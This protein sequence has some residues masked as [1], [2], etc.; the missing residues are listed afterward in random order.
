MGNSDSDTVE[1][2]KQIKQ[3]PYFSEDINITFGGKEEEDMINKFNAFDILWYAP[4]SSEKLQNWKA[5][6]NVDVFPISDEKEFMNIIENKTKLYYIVISTGSFAEKTIPKLKKNISPPVIIIYCMDYKHHK[7][8][9]QNYTFIHGVFTQPFQV[10]EYL[11]NLQNLGYDIPIFNYEINYEKEFNFNLY[12]NI[13]NEKYKVKENICS[14]KWNKYEKFC[15]D[16]LHYFRSACI[17]ADDY[18][19][20]FLKNISYMI[21]LFYGKNRIPEIG[22]AHILGIVILIKPELELLDF[23]IDLTLISLYF[24]K[25]PYFFGVLSYI[26]IESILKKDYTFEDLKKDFKELNRSHLK[27]I[28]LL[29]L[30]KNTSILGEVKDLKFLQIFLINYLKLFIKSIFKFEFDEYSKYPN[31]IYNLM[32][33]DFCLKLFFFRVYELLNCK[34]YKIRCRGSI[35]QIDKRI[36]V[37]NGKY[38]CKHYD[39]EKALKYISNENLNKLNESLKIRDF[40]IIGNENFH[41]EIKSIEKFFSDIKFVYLSKSEVRDYLKTRKKTDRYRNFTYFIIIKAKEAEKIYKDLYTLRNDFGLNLLLIVYLNNAKTLINKLPFLNGSFIP[42]YIVYNINNIINLI[43]C[44]KNLSCAFN[45]SE[46]STNISNTLSRLKFPK[47]WSENKNSIDNRISSEDGW[48]LVESVP[49]EIFKIKSSVVLA[50]MFLIDK[51]KVNMY[52]I[53]KENN[54]ESLFFEKYC[55]YFFFKIIPED[56]Y[57]SRNV[58]VKQFCY[59]YTLDEGKN[60]SFY[61]IM[62]RDLRSGNPSKIEKYI[63]I[64]SILN[65]A[66]EN[67][68]VKSF[69][70]ELFRG[71]GMPI[72]F[73]ENKI[74]EGKVLT[75]LSFWSA[76][77][78]REVAESFLKG[79]NILFIIK[80]KKNNIDIDEEKISKFNEK[81]VLFLPY[82]KFLIKSKKKTI[83]E[84]NEIYEVKLKGLDDEHQ[85]D[86][87]DSVPIT[88]ED[89]YNIYNK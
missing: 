67:N 33:L 89:F 83:F 86:S 84:N 44:Q 40:I 17:K 25:F 49:Q 9:S 45:F 88:R 2:T 6:T 32:D 69:E 70:G 65:E 26:E 39:R 53:Y 4:D 72:D 60:K 77:K 43:N 12:E 3:M 34:E 63:Q 80:T 68:Y 10:F 31:M 54:I 11:L 19:E 55:K 5:F 47:S 29:V 38:L 57:F 7:Q 30:E 81:E 18:Y 15:V 76:S 75:N 56:C 78:S 48:E 21:D 24:S 13:K 79:K 41:Q 35:D 36:L 52:K 74:V 62:N 14:L 20:H 22:G 58:V 23:F 46:S 37:F 50:G 42:I 27:N 87:I 28:F 1:Q 59:A 16:M 71:T 73:I 61:Y 82:S 66:I 64:I 8:W 51:L 85:R